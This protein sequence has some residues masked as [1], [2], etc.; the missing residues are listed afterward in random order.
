MPRILNYSQAILWSRGALPVA[1]PQR[2]RPFWPQGAAPRPDLFKLSV[3]LLALLVLAATAACSAMS[4]DDYAEECGEWV[5]EYESVGNDVSDLEDA[6]EDWNALKPPG[7]VKRLHELRRDAIRLSLEIAQD[8]ETLQDEL[9]DLEDQLD[10]A[11]RRE[12]GDIRDEMDDLRDEAEDRTDDLRD[13]LDD[14]FDD[15]ED[16]EDDLSRSERRELEREGCI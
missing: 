16:E 2:R 3:G 5:E 10:D 13:D 12:R 4:L 9:D 8:Y 6:L 11:S 14:V 7:E 1:G 15:L